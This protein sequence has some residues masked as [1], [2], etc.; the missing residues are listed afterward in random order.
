MPVDRAYITP[1]ATS[2]SDLYQAL[3]GLAS[4]S[5]GLEQAAGVRGGRAGSAAQTQAAAPPAASWA[6][7]AS[8]G[9]YLIEIT[10]PASATAPLQ[11]QLQSASNTNF[12][13]NS[14]TTTVTL[15]LGQTS[16]DVINP[17]VSLYWRIRSRFQGSTWNTWLLYA[18]AA[19]VVALNAGVLRT[20]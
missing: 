7:T 6:I 15:G 13:T 17:N 12:D 16:L 10:N 18:N 4:F 8:Q 20:S 1:Y 5:D 9:H 11:H 19:G 2:D 3:A 14:A